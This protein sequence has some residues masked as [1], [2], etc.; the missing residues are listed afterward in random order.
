MGNIDGMTPYT[1]LRLQKTERGGPFLH[2]FDSQQYRAS[3]AAACSYAAYVITRHRRRTADG[4]A[5][6]R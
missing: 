5:A 6:A 1:N 3:Q 2:D 4:T